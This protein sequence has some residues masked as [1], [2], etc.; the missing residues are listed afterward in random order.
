MSSIQGVS[1]SRLIFLRGL[2]W[3][4]IGLIYAPLFACLYVVFQGIGLGHG[5]FVPAAALAGM[6]GAAFY[7]A[8]QV[9]LAGTLVGLAV[10]TLLLFLVPGD[11]GFWL[12]TLSAAG[13]GGGLGWLVRFPDRC[14]LHVP[15]KAMAGLLTGAA[16][17]GLLAVVEPFHTESFHIAGAVAFLVSV[18]GVLY[19]AT[20]EWWIGRARIDRG[21]ACNLVESLVIAML[22]ATAAASLWAVAGPLI[23]AVDGRYAP[24]FGA[25][26]SQVPAAMTG[27]LIAGAVTGSL[28]QAF[29]FRWAHLD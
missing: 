17:G 22:A 21:R 15:G 2:I 10:G 24:L 12:M 1:R 7:G 27:G 20:L 29:G 28:L 16:C 3:S 18:N 19:V 13:V 23:G 25:M 8:R 14:S 5:S 26:F 6:V 9:A 11:V 4:V